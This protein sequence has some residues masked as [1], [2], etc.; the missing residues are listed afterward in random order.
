[1]SSDKRPRSTDA[2]FELLARVAVDPES[3][4]RYPDATVLIPA[5]SP[6]GSVLIS[7]AIDERR[8]IALVFADGSDV[9]ARPPR[10]DR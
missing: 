4:D 1:M 3:D 6:D 7:R 9:V 10:R 5:D 8:P 2:A